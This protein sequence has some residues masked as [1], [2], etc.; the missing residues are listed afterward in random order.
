MLEINNNEKKIIIKNSSKDNL[1]IDYDKSEI[2][3]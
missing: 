2:S 1:V 3:I